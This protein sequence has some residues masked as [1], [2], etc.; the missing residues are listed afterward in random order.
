MVIDKRTGFVKQIF[1]VE[2]REHIYYG[3]PTYK[4]AL[5]DLR[6]GIKAGYYSKKATIVVDYE[7]EST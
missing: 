6:M 7:D 4:E 3:S 5:K 1:L 2:D